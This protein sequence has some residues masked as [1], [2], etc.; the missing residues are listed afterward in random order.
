MSFEHPTPCGVVQ[1]TKAAKSWTVR[2][3]DKQRGLRPC[4]GTCDLANPASSASCPLSKTYFLPWGCVRP[5]LPCW[6]PVQAI[7]Q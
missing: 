6:V 2:F 4:R 1:L 5:R 7:K 3:A